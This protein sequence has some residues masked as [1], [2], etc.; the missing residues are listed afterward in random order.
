MC[1]FTLGTSYGENKFKPAHK[2]GSWYLW[3]VLFK[4]F[5]EHPP[6]LFVW[7]SPPRLV[8]SLDGMLFHCREPSSIVATDPWKLTVWIDSTHFTLSENEYIRANLPEEWTQAFWFRVR[9]ALQLFFL[10]L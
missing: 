5:H 3:R 1:Y 6:I 2:R 10:G 9:R 4:I 8:V 7:E